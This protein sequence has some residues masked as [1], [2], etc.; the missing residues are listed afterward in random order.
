MNGM[1]GVTDWEKRKLEIPLNFLGDCDYIAHI[2][3]DGPNAD[4]VPIPRIDKRV[5]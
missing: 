2:F 3:S 1:W 4:R 5:S